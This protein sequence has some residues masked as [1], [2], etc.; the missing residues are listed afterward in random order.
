MLSRE[1][2][3]DSSGIIVVTEID[4]RLDREVVEQETSREKE[5]ERL[6]LELKKG[7]KVPVSKF[8]SQ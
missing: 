8:I 4:Y 7:E 5:N 1:R 6:P 3:L 2:S